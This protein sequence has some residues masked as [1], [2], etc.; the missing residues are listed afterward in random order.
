ML[1]PSIDGF[2]VRI[3]VVVRWGIWPENVGILKWQVGEGVGAMN[4]GCVKERS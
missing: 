4:T 1:K 3:L 2:T